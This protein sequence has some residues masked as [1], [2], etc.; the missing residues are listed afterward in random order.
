MMIQL[1]YHRKMKR[2]LEAK[3]DTTSQSYIVHAGLL[4]RLEAEIGTYDG[5]GL[6]YDGFIEMP[7]FIYVQ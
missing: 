1:E 5:K 7:K 2:E 4:K 3:G 6:D